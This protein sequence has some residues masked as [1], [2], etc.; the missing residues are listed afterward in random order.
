LRASGVAPGVRSGAFRQVGN[1]DWLCASI[2]RYA[3]RGCAD[4]CAASGWLRSDLCG[5]RH[6]GDSESQAGLGRSKQLLRG[7]TFVVWAI[8]R[9][10]RST[11]DA[12]LFLDELINAGITFQSLTQHIDTGTPEGRKWFIDT[13]SWAEYERAIISRRT[14]E[15]MA[16]AKRR[17]QHLG[18]PRKLSDEQVRLAH[19]QLCIGG[20]S[21]ALASDLGASRDTLVRAI[22]R[23]G[24]R[25]SRTA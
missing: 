19:E 24:L 22:N 1:E 25:V 4:R 21:K 3:V 15:R 13:A 10:F 20:S 14:K 7:D 9:A 23:L 12:I 6:I 18:R 16:A 8:D 2:H 17:G 5:R 11:I